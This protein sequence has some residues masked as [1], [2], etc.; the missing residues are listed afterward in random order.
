M[1][2]WVGRVALVTG[3]SSGIGKAIA[4]SLVCHGMKV[5]GCARNVEAVEV[6]TKLSLLYK[7]YAVNIIRTLCSIEVSKKC[8]SS[9]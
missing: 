9:L 8:C 4:Q 1:E 3:A 7:M 2:R 6:N 5:V